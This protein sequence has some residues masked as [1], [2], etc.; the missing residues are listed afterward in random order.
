MDSDYKY[1]WDECQDI[2]VKEVRKLKLSTKL[3]DKMLEAW[4]ESLQYAR[5][6][7]CADAHEK[8]LESVR[9]LRLDYTEGFSAGF[10]L[11]LKG[12]APPQPQESNGVHYN[13]GRCAILGDEC[14]ALPKGR[15]WKCGVATS[16]A[17]ARREEEPRE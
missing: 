3:S 14:G 7:G 10:Q 11:G 6:Q 15:C 5:R 1:T 13:Q 2:I 12:I 17:L 8:A 16:A 9:L 4:A